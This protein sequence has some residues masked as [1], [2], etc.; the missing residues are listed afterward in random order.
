MSL[1][2]YNSIVF[3]LFVFYSVPAVAYKLTDSA[4]LNPNVIFI[5]VSLPLLI[6]VFNV[7]IK[8]LIMPVIL[9]WILIFNI[10]I[11]NVSNETLIYVLSLTSVFGVFAL[12][13]SSV[14]I[15]NQVFIK[16]VKK[17]SILNFILLFY[18]VIFRQ[19]IYLDRDK[20]NYM[21]FGYWMLTSAI[22][23]FYF[24]LV[25]NKIFYLFLAIFSAILIFMFGSRFAILCFVFSAL[26]L[27]YIFIGGGKRFFVILFFFC[28]IGLLSIFSIDLI[29][30]T[31]IDLAEFFDLIPKSLYRLSTNLAE[32][33]KGVSSGRDIIYSESIDLISNNPFGVGIFG[34]TKVLSEQAVF[35]YPHNFFLQTTLEY[36]LVGAAL[37]LALLFILCLKN[38]VSVDRDKGWLFF[39][40][41]VLNIKLLVTGSYL[42]EPTFWMCIGIG[43]KN[44]ITNKKCLR[45]R[46]EI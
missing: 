15:N 30:I 14:P 10:L 16:Y 18:L 8:L 28:V 34:Y 3:A 4:L 32:G 45:N 13:V 38:F 17:L 22:I 37:I 42:W 2:K 29:L 12:I 7:N 40:L 33:L 11:S 36:G 24:Y 20:M 25:E 5:G 27:R 9:C 31:L 19:D 46:K 44:L 39:V 35:K 43:I 26:V 41:L 1:Q 21:T 23:F 6:S